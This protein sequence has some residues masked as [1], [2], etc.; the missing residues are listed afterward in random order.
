MARRGVPRSNGTLGPRCLCLR[1]DAMSSVSRVCGTLLQGGCSQRTTRHEEEH[2]LS[3]L[4]AGGGPRVSPQSLSRRDPG[5]IP[6]PRI[7]RRAPRTR[8]WVCVS[9][10]SPRLT[11]AP[12]RNPQRRELRTGASQLG[13]TS[14]VGATHPDACSPPA[15][16][17]GEPEPRPRERRPHTCNV[18]SISLSVL[19]DLHRVPV[20]PAAH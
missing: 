14:R 8:G 15:G 2:P 11:A 1:T 19:P 3:H 7:R 12:N 13:A 4:A 6:S 5:C 10:S 18:T 20:T 16:P 9:S 17:W